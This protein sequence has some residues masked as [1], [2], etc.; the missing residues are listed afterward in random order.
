[1]SVAEDIRLESYMVQS[2]DVL[3]VR[4][5]FGD[6]PAHGRWRAM[7]LT[8]GLVASADRGYRRREITWTRYKSDSK[9]ALSSRMWGTP[10]PY[11]KVEFIKLN[12]WELT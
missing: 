5:D 2:P 4:I 1:V 8:I 3:G 9:T 6:A 12:T 10:E 11:E 7:S